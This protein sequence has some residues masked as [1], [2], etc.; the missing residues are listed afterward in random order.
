MFLMPY[1]ALQVGHCEHDE[2][3]RLKATIK[4]LNKLINKDYTLIEAISELPDKW[5]SWENDANDP[6]NCIAWNMDATEC[7]DELQALIKQHD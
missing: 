5:R 2:N 7:A 1:R 6:D 4:T 3:E